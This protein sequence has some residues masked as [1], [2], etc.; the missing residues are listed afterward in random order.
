L[1]SLGNYTC[2]EDLDFNN[3]IDAMRSQQIIPRLKI[4][5]NAIK[6]K[7]SKKCHVKGLPE[8]QPAKH[9]QTTETTERLKK[10]N[11]QF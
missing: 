4:L 1:Y 5:Y 8:S 3:E 2:D 11:S 10:V 7:A 9:K 6:K